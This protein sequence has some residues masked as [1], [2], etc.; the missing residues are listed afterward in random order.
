M[1][2]IL[3]ERILENGIYKIISALY[4]QVTIESSALALERASI[5]TTFYTP[6]EQYVYEASEACRKNML[7]VERK[8]AQGLAAAHRHTLQCR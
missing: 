6:L 5:D 1:K 7:E 3:R 4:K 2:I 8:R